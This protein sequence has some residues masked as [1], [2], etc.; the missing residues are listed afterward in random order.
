MTDEVHDIA[1]VAIQQ[2]ECEC[3]DERELQMTHKEGIHISG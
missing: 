2:E 3:I 1:M